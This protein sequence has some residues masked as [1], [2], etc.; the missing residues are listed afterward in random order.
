MTKPL[1]YSEM[2]DR[3]G[4]GTKHLLLGNGFS[5]ACD[6]RFNYPNLFDYA[7]K[8]GLSNRAVALFERLGTNNFEGVLRM[9]EDTRWAAKKYGITDAKVLGLMKDDL[10]AIKNALVEAISETHLEHSGF[11]PEEKKSC[12]IDFLSEYFNVFTTN[13]DLLL[14]WVAMHAPENIRQQ[15]GFRPPLEDVEDEDEYVDPKYL[16]F[17]EH[18]G[19]FRGIFFLHGALH[20]FVV[21]GEVRKHSWKG[22]GTRLTKLVR[23]GLDEGHYPLFVAEGKP[24][25][26]RR[27]IQNSGYLSYCLGK[28]ER[29]ET[30]LVLIGHSLGDSDQHILDTI[31]D[32]EKVKTI[33]VGLFDDHQSSKGMAVMDAAKR[34]QTRRKRWKGFPDLDVIFFDTKTAPVWRS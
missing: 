22:T 18:T 24:D 9:L 14:Y 33:A 20:I 32:N 30:P 16:I 31:S 28:L 34:M 15:D 12:C 5:I 8:H 11:V 25:K 29:I 6:K 3:L 7:R 4:S 10:T 17:R 26:K 21:D 1:K 2:L 27:Q 23:A 13:Y 19:R